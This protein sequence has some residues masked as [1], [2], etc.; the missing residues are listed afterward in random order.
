MLRTTPAALWL[1]TLLLAC[2]GSQAPSAAGGEAAGAGAEEAGAEGEAGAAAEAAG[3]CG[4]PAA[5][6]SVALD[7]SLEACADGYMN[8]SWVCDGGRS[9]LT[10]ASG[11]MRFC[12]AE[13]TLTGVGCLSCE[14]AWEAIARDGSWVNVSGTLDGAGIMAWRW[15][16]GGDLE[17][18]RA[19]GGEGGD[20][21]TCV[22]A[23]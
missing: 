23:E 1:M 14:G 21:Y 20:E 4:D 3:D 5:A 22:R 9:R 19:S 15:C 12:D 13:N 2:G 7:C 10:I 6:A 8:G 11:A 16:R 18:C 17:A